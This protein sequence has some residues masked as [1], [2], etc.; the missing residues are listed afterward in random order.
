MF[1]AVI[2]KVYIFSLRNA[3]SKERSGE[4][5]TDISDNT[6]F[7]RESGRYP[8]LIKKGSHIDVYVLFQWM[9]L[10]SAGQDYME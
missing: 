9:R 4:R 1:K 8:C 3:M 6:L 2:I 10:D 5:G 7:G